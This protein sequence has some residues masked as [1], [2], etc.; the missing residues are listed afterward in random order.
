MDARS[1]VGYLL[2][3]GRAFEQEAASTLG[4]RQRKA[5]GKLGRLAARELGIGSVGQTLSGI[6]FDAELKKRGADIE[7]RYRFF[8]NSVHEQLARTSVAKPTLRLGGNSAEL[9]RRLARANDAVKLL[10]RVQRVNRFLE[11][12]AQEPLVHNGDIPALLKQRQI[13]RLQEERERKELRYIDLTDLPPGFVSIRFPNREALLSRLNEF[14]AVR[15]TMEGAIHAASGDAP[16]GRQQALGSCRRALE[17]LGRELTGK[18]DW[19]EVVL[20]VA[21]EDV[22]ALLKKLYSLLSAKGAHGGKRASEADVEFGTQQTF[23]ALFWMIQHRNDLKV[24]K[25]RQ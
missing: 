3:Q 16:D 24:G 22:G 23:G 10:T 25:P 9:V 4:K 19:R 6:L 5:A 7:A 14:P 1:S 17:V 18:G 8:Y 20:R 2:A 15:E 13:Q 21:D 12:L 11:R